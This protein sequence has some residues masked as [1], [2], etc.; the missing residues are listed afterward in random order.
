M[1]EDRKKLAD[2]IEDAIKKYEHNTD[3]VSDRGRAEFVADMLIG[4]GYEKRR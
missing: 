4:A 2:L 1:S 3:V